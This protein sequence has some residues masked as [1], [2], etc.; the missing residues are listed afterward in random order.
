MPA[1]AL[2]TLN[3]PAVVSITIASKFKYLHVFYM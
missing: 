2:K 3:V 1:E